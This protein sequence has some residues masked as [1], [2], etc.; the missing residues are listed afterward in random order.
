MCSGGLFLCIKT[1][2][3][4]NRAGKVDFI[5]FL[6]RK[7]NNSNIHK[8]SVNGRFSHQVW[9]RQLAVSMDAPF[10]MAS[11]IAKVTQVT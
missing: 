5:I 10:G 9:P 6:L 11:L 2:V 3:T 4:G 8:S 1:S 7:E